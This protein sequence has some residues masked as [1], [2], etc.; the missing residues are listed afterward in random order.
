MYC[1]IGELKKAL[2]EQGA[3]SD[4]PIALRHIIRHGQLP[5][6]GIGLGGFDHQ[7]HIGSPLELVVDIDD[8]IFQV[9]LTAYFDT[10]LLS[11][12]F[13]ILPP[14]EFIWKNYP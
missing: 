9:Y 14:W 4:R 8:L 13:F 1:G 7:P 6:S 5:C 11:Q 12:Y 3:G 10:I 2:P